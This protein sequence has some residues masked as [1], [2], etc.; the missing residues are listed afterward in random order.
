[1]RHSTVPFTV[2]EEFQAPKQH[3]LLGKGHAYHVSLLQ[4]PRTM[5]HL[6]RPHAH[7]V[8]VLG[9]KDNVLFQKSEQDSILAA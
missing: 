6:V 1:M 2:Q 8:A 3:D 9:R 5:D 4:S 7:H